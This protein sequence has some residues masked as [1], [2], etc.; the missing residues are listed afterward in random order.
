MMV[1]DGNASKMIAFA[2]GITQR[3]VETHRASVMLKTG[4]RSLPALVKLHVE[5]QRSDQESL[6]A[7]GDARLSHLV[8]IKNERRPKD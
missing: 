4:A 1:L 5:S 6:H 8:E 3:T 7:A 2:L